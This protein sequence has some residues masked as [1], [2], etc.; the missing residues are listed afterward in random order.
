M[1]WNEL[2]EHILAKSYFSWFYGVWSNYLFYSLSVCLGVR[3]SIKFVILPH[4]PWYLNE[5]MVFE[6]FLLLKTRPLKLNY[7]GK[8][9]N[10]VHSM[11]ISC[12]NL[13]F[14]PNFFFSQNVHLY[15]YFRILLFI[16]ILFLIFLSIRFF[17]HNFALI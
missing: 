11:F 1:L 2:G 17:Y 5:W 14:V 7:F 10:R 8:V 9:G 4:L 13:I 6:N 3:R 15:I 12:P 16:A